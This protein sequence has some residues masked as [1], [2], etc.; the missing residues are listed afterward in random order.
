MELE[1]LHIGNLGPGEL[2]QGDTAA[3]GHIGVGGVLEEAPGAAGSQNQVTAPVFLGSAAAAV[4]NPDSFQ[5]PLSQ[6]YLSGQAV[7]QDLYSGLAY[8]LA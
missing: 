2:G 4:E 8:P 7:L 3:G 5:F 6:C 1:K